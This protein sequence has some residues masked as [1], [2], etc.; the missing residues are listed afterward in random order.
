MSPV[1]ST[2]STNPSRSERG[3]ACLVEARSAVAGT[4]LAVAGGARQPVER[5]LACQPFAARHSYE[6]AGI[7]SA[8]LDRGRHFV[9]KAA[10]S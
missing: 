4:A 2:V 5:E 10:P 8:E 1:T 6:N 7:G 3:L 9:A